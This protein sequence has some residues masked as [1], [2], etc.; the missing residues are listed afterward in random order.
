MDPIRVLKRKISWMCQESRTG[1]QNNPVIPEC[2]N[3]GAV[4]HCMWF[5]STA[6][7]HFNRKINKKN[8]RLWISKNPL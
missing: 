5:S 8:I 1:L 4:L 3:K 2:D 7:F 6:Y